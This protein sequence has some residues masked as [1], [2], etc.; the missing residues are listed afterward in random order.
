MPHLEFPIPFAHI[1]HPVLSI[2]DAP[3]VPGGAVPLGTPPTSL[4]PEAP[5]KPICRRPRKYE[6][7]SAVKCTTLHHIAFDPH[8]RSSTAPLPLAPRDLLV[9]AAHL[10]VHTRAWRRHYGT[11]PSATWEKAMTLNRARDPDADG[12]AWGPPLLQV[13]WCRAQG[14]PACQNAKICSRWQ[15]RIPSGSPRG[16]LCDVWSGA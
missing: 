2:R 11:L 8:E 14:Q 4:Y 1:A 3:I 5:H 15:R 6:E 12:R 13:R 16:C 9:L 7:S 10:P